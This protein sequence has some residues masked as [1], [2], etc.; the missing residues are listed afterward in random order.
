MAV[1]FARPYI[2]TS[3][4]NLLTRSTKRMTSGD[5]NGWAI[6]QWRPW[7][8]RAPIKRRTSF[9]H[10]FFGQVIH[11]QQQ[12]H[13][14]KN[15]TW[16]NIKIISY[17]IEHASY[18]IDIFCM[19][20]GICCSGTLW[21]EP[22]KSSHITACLHTAVGE[23]EPHLSHDEQKEDVSYLFLTRVLQLQRFVDHPLQIPEKRCWQSAIQPWLLTN[24]TCKPWKV[25]IISRY[26]MLKSYKNH[27]TDKHYWKQ[28]Q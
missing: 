8:R 17:N 4:L 6:L 19:V 3:W 12:Y 23:C 28:K 2:D 14:Y 15:G 1:T 20:A 26:R 5:G 9:L 22:T 24:C 27:H 25:C 11:V 10:H 13:W 21:R 18:T 7:Q 16:S